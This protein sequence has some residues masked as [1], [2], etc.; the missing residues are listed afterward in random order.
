MSETAGFEKAINSL[1]REPLWVSGAL[2][3]AGVLL[4]TAD[5]HHGF[6]PIGSPYLAP[7]TIGTVVVACLFVG[8]VMG[9]IIEKTRGRGGVRKPLNA[10][11][12]QQREMLLG[13]YNTGTRSFQRYDRS[14]P[15]WIEE[16]SEW[17]YIRREPSF[18][19][20]ADSPDYYSMTEAGWA[21]IERAIRKKKT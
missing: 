15:R 20:T 9:L 12:E 10:V 5:R 7:I 6:A 13:V 19:I 8:R 2:T 16:L 14:T 4:L 17:G 1:L 11:S 21:H 18:I 3:V